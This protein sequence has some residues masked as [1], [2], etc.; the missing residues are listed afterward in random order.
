MRQQLTA[1]RVMSD[2]FFQNS[3]FWNQ[4]CN[5]HITILLISF[6]LAYAIPSFNRCSFFLCRNDVM[7]ICTDWKLFHVFL[8][9]I[10]FFIYFCNQEKNNIQRYEESTYNNVWMSLSHHVGIL[11]A[12][13]GRGFGCRNIFSFRISRH[14]L[15]FPYS[16]YILYYL[17]NGFDYSFQKGSTHSV[18]NHTRHCYCSIMFLDALI[19]KKRFH[20]NLGNIK[21]CF[22][23]NNKNHTLRHNKP[24]KV[25]G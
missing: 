13:S 23:Q 24:P 9:H 5:L 2:E 7:E 3:F 12:S 21:L 15:Y 8:W 22:S 20:I 1:L 19:S 25:L 17:Y 18:N 10:R 6:R 11:Y 16:R 4:N 14:F